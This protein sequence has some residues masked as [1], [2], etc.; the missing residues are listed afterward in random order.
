MIITL[1][2]FCGNGQM[3]R[4][5]DIVVIGAGL[6]GYQLS[7]SLR[8]I[9][10]G[11]NIVLLGGEPHAPY[12]RPPL[13]KDFLSGHLRLSDLEFETRDGLLAQDISL[14][15]GIEIAAVDRRLKKVIGIDGTTFNYDVLVFATGSRNRALPALPAGSG[16]VCGI[17]SIADAEQ[18]RQAFVKTSCLVII[19]GGVLGL[20]V[21]S[22]AVSHGITT[23]VVEQRTLPMLG[24]LSPPASKHV[25]QH[26]RALGVNFHFNRR[27]IGVGAK[28]GLVDRLDL[29]D[30][31]SLAPDAIL[32]SI[33]VLPNVELAERAG[34][35]TGNGIFVDENFRTDDCSIYAIGD[36]AA[37]PDPASG[38]QVRLESV[39][40]AIAQAQHVAGVLMGRKER[41]DLL[42]TFWSQQGSLRLQVA[43]LSQ[44]ADSYQAERGPADNALSVKCYR[45]GQLIAVESLNWP[46]DHK[47]ARTA[48]SVL[49]PV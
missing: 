2:E 1:N 39:R 12:S 46:Q 7:R 25:L 19:G 26:H 48:L 10:F 9:G 32:L 44:S 35:R 11:G 42:P 31:I 5:Q 14:H 34:L 40:S 29:D 21:A 47:A 20:E 13:S 28:A 45:S 37:F 18:L 22:I 3:D 41:Y 23:H 27:V 6:A 36:C 38:R 24:V 49:A 43:G 33:G 15:S 4:M 17:R 30:G 16:N 8:Q